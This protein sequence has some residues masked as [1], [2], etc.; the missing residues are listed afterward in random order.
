MYAAYNLGH[1]HVLHTD[2]PRFTTLL[3]EDPRPPLLA[4]VLRAWPLY[5]VKEYHHPPHGSPT[6]EVEVET[7]PPS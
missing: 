2:R 1:S 4:R 7:L 6:L 5:W 3:V